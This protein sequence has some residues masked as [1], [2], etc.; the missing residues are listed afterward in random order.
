[1]GIA[2][3]LGRRDD[4]GI[5]GLG[6]WEQVSATIRLSHFFATHPPFSPH[7]SVPSGSYERVPLRAPVMHSAGINDYDTSTQACFMILQI[8]RAM[9]QL[10][11]GVYV[12]VNWARLRGRVVA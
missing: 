1:M 12:A 7:D 5:A 9:T 10:T 3:S 6:T 2:P 4:G 8:T 11:V